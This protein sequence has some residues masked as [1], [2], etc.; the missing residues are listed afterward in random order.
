MSRRPHHRV[1]GLSP[2]HSLRSRVGH[3][4]RC[5]GLP[6]VHRFTALRLT[7]PC[8]RHL[9]IVDDDFPLVLRRC[10]TVRVPESRRRAEGRRGPRS[11]ADATHER[12]QPTGRATAAAQPGHAVALCNRVKVGRG[13]YCVNR[14][15]S[16][17]PLGCAHIRPVGIQNP[18]RIFEYIQMLSKFK[19][20]C[21][22]HLNSESCETNFVR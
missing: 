12:A 1:L 14:P 5:F 21:R 20:L 10:L 16:I 7:R 6:E 9:D 18:F 3:R 11:R 4:R 8:L 19:N 17:V 13:W 22:I 2:P 15:C